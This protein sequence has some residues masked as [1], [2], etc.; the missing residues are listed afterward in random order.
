MKIQT[1]LII[2]SI[3]F[4]FSCTNELPN[5]DLTK[6]NI[7]GKVN[8]IRCTEYEA[9]EKFGE[10]E[11]GEVKGGWTDSYNENGKLI[12]RNNYKYDGSLRDKRL[13]KYD[14]KG[15]KIEVNFYNA[16]GS[17]SSKR[18]DKTNEKGNKIEVSFYNADGSFNYLNT[19][20]YKY[21]K[22]GNIIEEK[23]YNPKGHLI[24]H[25]KYDDKGNEIEFNEYKLPGVL[26]L[27]EINK[28]NRKG[29]IVEKKMY[30][31]G[32][33]TPFRSY[34]YKYKL[35]KHNNWIVKESYKDGNPYR[36]EEREISYI[37]T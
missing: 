5:N 30:H 22:N 34:K 15:N 23:W 33:E 29:F 16:D 1:L 6:N 17:L 18:F 2:G 35:D 26:R 4:Q 3:S 7:K 10:I 27:K 24:W 28:Y 37:K 14:E 13:I 8:F 25:V 12:E 31:K 20:N 19:I 32:S 21:D 11:K 9:I 36:I